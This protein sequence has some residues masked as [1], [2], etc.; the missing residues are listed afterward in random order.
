MKIHSSCE[1]EGF[2]ETHLCKLCVIY[3]SLYCMGSYH[4]YLYAFPDHDT[5]TPNLY[6]GMAFMVCKKKTWAM[7]AIAHTY[8]TVEQQLSNTQNR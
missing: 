6:L 8:R 3:I 4:R 5:E 1:I 7:T 2:V